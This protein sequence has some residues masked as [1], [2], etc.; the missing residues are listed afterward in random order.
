LQAAYSGERAAALAYRGHW[1]SVTSPAVR[2]RIREIE[3]DEWRHREQVGQM[4]HELGAGPRRISEMRAA[5][6]GH[7]LGA[8]CHIAGRLLP[9]YGA[10]M[11]ESKNVREYERAARLAHRA[12]YP[13]WVDCL[14]EMAEV[15]WDH[16]AAFRAL[17][18][19]HPV[20]RRLPL[21]AQPPP[22][23][24]IRRAFE[25]ELTAGRSLAVAL[26]P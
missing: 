9:L 13:E 22:R 7:G 15:E 11:L 12:G 1:R 25:R 16:E 6:V 5:A 18:I 2:D 10:G 14:L 19:A 21:W 20:G 17:V 24:T 8:L 3:R 23:D 26:T 4:L